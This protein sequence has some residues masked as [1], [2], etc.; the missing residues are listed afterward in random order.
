MTDFYRAYGLCIASE[1]ALP[2]LDRCAPPEGGPDLDIRIGDLPE[3]PDPSE[4]WRPIS[5]FVHVAEGRFR[6]DIPGVARFTVEDGSRVRVAPQDGIDAA[7]VRVFLLGSV[8][9][10]VMFQRGFLVLHGNAIDIGGQAMVCLGPSG[11]GKST[12][13]A[14][15]AARGYPVL[16]DDVVP[17]DAD[18]AA[19]P[20]FPRIKL[21]QDA[22][23]RLDV[24]TDG[25]DRIRPGLE[26]FNL[27]LRTAFRDMPLPIRW[28]Y[29]L[30]STNADTITVTPVAGLN[31]FKPLLANTYRRRF[32]EGMS[33]HPEH[34]QRCGA[35][36]GRVHL[37]RVV[38]PEKGF[39]IDGLAEALLADM[40]WAG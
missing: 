6:L 10:A 32:M 13:A 14:A 15:M 3:T 25:L 12:L 27:P 18:C 23:E 30:N 40:D 2:E 1:P 37:A 11:T 38:R 24:A 33:L 36:A 39:D 35:L 17:V 26:K 31:R 9:G 16:A 34:L 7:S 5:P 20:G 19:V 29:L 22:A 21:W 8:L 4:G 28:I